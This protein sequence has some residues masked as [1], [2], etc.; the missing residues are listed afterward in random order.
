ML[1]L[2]QIPQEYIQW[3]QENKAP[4]GPDWWGKLLTSRMRGVNFIWR[5]RITLLPFS[6]MRQLGCFAFQLNSNTRIF[7]YPWCFHATPLEP[8]MQVVEIGAAASGFQFV[9]ANSGLKVT[10]VD[11]LINPSEEVKWIFTEKEFS[12]LN[13]AFGDKV[14][15]IHNFLQNINLPSNSVDR[16]FSVSVIEHI[17][18]QEIQLLLEEI[19]RILTPGGFFIATIDL[20]LNCAPFT[21]KIKNKFGSNIS[22]AELLKSSNLR[23]KVG[24]LEE[25]YGYPEFDK[26]KI[27]ERLDKFLVVDNVLTQCIV[28]EKIL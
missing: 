12:R 15:F 14:T 9:L 20:F 24:N 1:A 26:D 23:L 13:H 27:L 10:S 21:N 6:V 11:P 17:P 5:N 7:E 2:K 22:I 28:V 8:E 4:F 3:N 18:P 19:I 16:V 25:L